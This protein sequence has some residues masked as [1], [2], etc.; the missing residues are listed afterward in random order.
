MPDKE[1][2]R[3][4]AAGCSR[5]SLAQPRGKFRFLPVS[6][7]AVHRP[8]ETYLTEASSLRA[9]ITCHHCS[10]FTASHTLW[11]TASLRNPF[12]LLVTAAVAHHRWEILRKTASGSL[13]HTKRSFQECLLTL[14]SIYSVF[15]LKEGSKFSTRASA[16]LLYLG[17]KS[18]LLAQESQEWKGPA[19]F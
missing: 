7:A 9:C 5:N 14:G 18:I 12:Q 8:W 6:E 2:N 17:H 15:R 16:L 13:V 11:S 4:Y 10:C 19:L 3:I 1:R